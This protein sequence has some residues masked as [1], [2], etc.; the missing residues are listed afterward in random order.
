MVRNCVKFIQTCYHTTSNHQMPMHECQSLCNC[1]T[2]K[3]YIAYK[4]STRKHCIGMHTSIRRP[5]LDVS[6]LSYTFQGYTLCECTFWR[7]Y[8]PGGVPGT[9]NAPQKGPQTRHTNLEGILDQADPPQ[10]RHGPRHTH[11]GFLTFKFN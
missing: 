5:P 6:I 7:V 8:L 10:K 4:D 2:I 9:P 11:P 1:Q 3:K